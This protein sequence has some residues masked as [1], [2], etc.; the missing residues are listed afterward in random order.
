[1][2]NFA[3]E[4]DDVCSERTLTFFHCRPG[5]QPGDF[6]RGDVRCAER[7][8][9]GRG[10]QRDTDRLRVRGRDE[11]HDREESLC[12]YRGGKEKMMNFCIS[13]RE[14]VR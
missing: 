14:I 2:V 8:P 3:L 11:P 13:K 12:G 6:S 5:Y 9:A 10:S 4:N 7:E 1:M